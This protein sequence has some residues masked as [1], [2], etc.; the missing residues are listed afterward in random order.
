MSQSGF[1][2]LENLLTLAIVSTLL[3]GSWI[4]LRQYQAE[5]RLQQFQSHFEQLQSASLAYFFAHCH[6]QNFNKTSITIN[7]LLNSG[8]ISHP[9]FVNNPLGD[10]FQIELSHA[11]HDEPAYAVFTA[12]LSR[13]PKASLAYFHQRLGAT[14]QGAR[15]IWRRP[16]SNILSATHEVGPRWKRAFAP[17]EMTQSVQS[18][19]WTSRASL[20]AFRESNR[21]SQLNPQASCAL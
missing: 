14:G 15:F 17:L 1:G 4:W 16:L 9:A 7:D 19:L 11:N 20:L 2:L 13:L 10:A 3:F 6:G 21:I 12:Q 18:P 8:A 5:S